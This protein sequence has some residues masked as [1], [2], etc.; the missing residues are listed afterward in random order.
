MQGIIIIGAGAGAT[1]PK[2]MIG[3][4]G[5]SLADAV[6]LDYCGGGGSGATPN[7]GP[8]FGLVNMAEVDGTA[9]LM[10]MMETETAA[11]EAIAAS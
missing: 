9:A 3:N 7:D 1:T 2:A 8:G 10:N 11:P 5:S 4:V 6:G